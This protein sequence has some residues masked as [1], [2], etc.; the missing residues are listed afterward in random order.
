MV[1]GSSNTTIIS[2]VRCASSAILTSI[3][4]H[5]WIYHAAAAPMGSSP[6]SSPFP[7]RPISLL[8]TGSTVGRSMQSHYTLA[9]SLSRRIDGSASWRL[10]AHGAKLEMAAMSQPPT[11]PVMRY[12][13]PQT[14]DVSPLFVRSK[15]RAS[16]DH[17]S[18]GQ[19]LDQSFVARMSLS[20]PVQLV[21][22]V[23][24]RTKNDHVELSQTIRRI[25]HIYRHDNDR[26]LLNVAFWLMFAHVHAR[27]AWELMRLAFVLLAF[28]HVSS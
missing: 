21:Y 10:V 6:L 22:A 7:S 13:D 9:Q 28:T 20:P 27:G 17:S 1:P 19:P 18:K 16:R 14:E 3:S 8:M 11:L 2:S 4:V 15:D 23:Q 24:V 26:R 5:V 25:C 12:S